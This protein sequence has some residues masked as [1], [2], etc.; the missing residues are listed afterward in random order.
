[1]ILKTKLKAFLRDHGLPVTGKK[2]DLVARVLQSFILSCSITNLDKGGP[3]PVSSP[4]VKAG[5]SKAK[6]R[7]ERQERH[8]TSRASSQL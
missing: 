1:M 5:D 4:A 7:Q 2:D 3:R 6:E 8:Q